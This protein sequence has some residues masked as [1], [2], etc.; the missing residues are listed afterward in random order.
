MSLSVK[1]SYGVASRVEARAPISHLPP[2]P[3]CTKRGGSQSRCS[4]QPS[5][6][7][8]TNTKQLRLL[9]CLSNLN[10]ITINPLIQ[11]HQL[12][13]H[14]PRPLH[15]SSHHLHHLHH[16][17]HQY[18]HSCSNN[19][20]FS[21]HSYSHLRCVSLHRSNALSSPSGPLQYGPY[22]A[23]NSQDLSLTTLFRSST[24]FSLPSKISCQSRHS[25]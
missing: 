18:Q 25:C 6:D 23:F 7:L 1:S 24:G 16:L 2:P 4:W 19:T 14:Q 3:V 12:H 8:P 22:R 15:H 17:H 21:T 13:H 5:N 10:I 9:G 11:P 20:R